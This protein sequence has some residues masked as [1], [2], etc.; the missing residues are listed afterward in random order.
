MARFE[1]VLLGARV[2]QGVPLP[3]GQEAVKMASSRARTYDTLSFF[4]VGHHLLTQ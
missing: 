2:A 4:G 1:F 3:A